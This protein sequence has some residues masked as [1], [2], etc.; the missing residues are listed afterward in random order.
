VD[1]IG[2][3]DEPNTVIITRIQEQKSILQF[4]KKYDKLLLSETGTKMHI[5]GGLKSFN[6]QKG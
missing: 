1:L 5:S 2:L 4:I 6:C 3:I